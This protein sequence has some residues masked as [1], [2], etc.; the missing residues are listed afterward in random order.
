MITICIRCQNFRNLEPTGPRKD[1]WYNHLCTASPLPK[2]IDPY[3]GRL[4]H[5]DQPFAFCRDINN[6][7]CPLF[8]PRVTTPDFQAQFK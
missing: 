4:K 6:G 1:V 8:D 5:E 7:S 3:D 2:V